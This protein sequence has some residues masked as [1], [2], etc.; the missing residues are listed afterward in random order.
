MSFHKPPRRCH[1]LR[2]LRHAFLLRWFCLRGGQRPGVAEVVAQG[3]EGFPDGVEFLCTTGRAALVAAA[4]P[5]ARTP[6]T[7]SGSAAGCPPGP[8][9][10]NARR[11]QAVLRLTLENLNPFAEG[12]GLSHG[13]G[14]ELDD[15]HDKEPQV[16]LWCRVLEKGHAGLCTSFSK[17]RQGLLLEMIGENS[18]HRAHSAHLRG[19]MLV[20]RDIVA[21]S[22]ITTHSDMRFARLA[23]KCWRLASTCTRLR[24]G[25]GLPGRRPG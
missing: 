4:G 12:V 23:W 10:G 20:L 3:P 14:A 8:L 1:W 13:G 19:S 6:R 24:V 7:P 21:A 9:A 22:G 18:A 15:V 17:A 25:S 11:P 16:G 2:R 5:A